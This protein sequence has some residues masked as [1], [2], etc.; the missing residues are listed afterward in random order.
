[1]R[2]RVDGRKCITRNALSQMSCRIVKHATSEPLFRL[3]GNLRLMWIYV[4]VSFLVLASIL[5][6][7]DFTFEPLEFVTNILAKGLQWNTKLSLIFN[8]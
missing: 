3:H 4:K 2:L 7:V 6:S 1:M 5:L 8:L